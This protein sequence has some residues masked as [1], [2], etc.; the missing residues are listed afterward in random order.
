MLLELYVE[1][2]AIISKLRLALAA[3]LNAL[4]GE[5]GAGKSLVVDAVA[6]LIGG[7]GGDGFIR[8]GNDRC[9]IEGVF[10]RP[11]SPELEALLAEQGLTPEQDD[12]LVLSRELVRGGRSICRING[13]TVTLSQLRGLGMFL[14]N[15][16]GQM[17][18]ML[19]LEEGRQLELLD[20]Y[21]GEQLLAAKRLVAACYDEMQA[22]KKRL[23]DYEHNKEQRAERMALLQEQ[24]EELSTAQLQIDEEQALREESRRLANAEKLTALS[25]EAQQALDGS[26]T[27]QESLSLAVSLLRQ[28]AHLDQS[29]DDLRERTE[30]LYF[31][32]EDVAFQLAAYKNAINLDGYRLERVEERLALLGRLR[33]KY[34]GDIAYL[35]NYLDEAQRELQE[36]DE[37]DYSGG[38]SSQAVAA[39]TARYS[40][41][42]HALTTLRQEAAHKLSAAISEELHLLCMEQAEFRIELLPNEA[43]RWGNEKALYMIRT[44]VGEEFGPVAKIA[45]GGELSRIVLGM[46]VI[47]AQLDQVPTLIFDEVDSGLGGRALTAVARRLAYVGQSTQG[48]LVT[49]APVMA[50]AAGRQL[51][52][53]KQV[54][55]GR[56]EISATI[57][58]GDARLDELARMIAGDKISATTRQQAW[59]LMNSMTSFV[60]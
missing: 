30:T 7:R 5:T 50:A 19:L 17:E 15:I 12:L 55:Q 40:E 13:R 2:F 22:Q 25:E 37:L 38:K 41:A 51:H 10:A 29:V 60:E 47:L 45:S 34:G 23:A 48:I 52:I 53:S 36:L 42:A 33:K 35:L 46:K 9:L 57:L 16:H 31:E 11:F 21:G 6:L 3:G 4:T 20:S 14:L 27:A 24:I 54:V 56:T 8:S 58:E 28:I 26:G 32:V 1:N 44:N 39:A 18:H 43:A 49:H 59:E